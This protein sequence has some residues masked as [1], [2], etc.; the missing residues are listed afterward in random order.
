VTSYV[1]GSTNLIR[2]FCGLPPASAPSASSTRCSRPTHGQAPE[3]L[4]PL[5]ARAVTALASSPAP[6]SSPPPSKQGSQRPCTWSPGCQRRYSA[7]P[8]QPPLNHHARA[9]GRTGA[10]NTTAVAMCSM[11]LGACATP[12]RRGGQPGSS[13]SIRHLAMLPTSRNVF[14]ENAEGIVLSLRM[15]ARTR[16]LARISGV[17]C[18]HGR[19]WRCRGKCLD[20]RAG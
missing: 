5:S 2:S 8:R 13:S 18:I 16:S 1:D 7:S 9:S 19:L 12:F 15:P 10:G 17:A 11:P 14:G 4:L 6:S 20:G 3:P